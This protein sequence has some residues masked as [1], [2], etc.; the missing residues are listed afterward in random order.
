MR[1]LL[2]FIINKGSWGL[3]ILLEIF[4]FV[5][6][7]RDNPYQ[8]TAIL[9]SANVV[10][11]NISSISG[12]INSYFNLRVINKDLAEKNSHMEMELLKL[13][14]QIDVMKADT[15]AFKGFAESSEDSFSYDFVMARVIN[16]SVGYLSN[17]I[18]IDKGIKDGVT[19]DM[20]VVSE[21]GVVGVVVT[22]SENMAVVLPIINSKSILSCQV[23]GSGYGFLD[24][25]GTN[26]Q[27]AK[28]KISRHMNIQ[29]GDTIITS[30]YSSIFPVGLVVGTISSSERHTDD[31]FYF[32]NVRLSTNFQTLSNVRVIRNY[33]RAEQISLEQSA[34]DI[35]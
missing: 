28:M 10:V 1:K 35:S 17:Y 16:N 5:L 27:Y 34:N 8:R 14:D 21:R 2:D 26:L 19:K 9:S 7:Y 13:Q 24:W 3:F 23:K 29:E 25:D 32:L 18:T 4:A 11:G 6:I 33:R 31:N 12:N 30:G 22:A 15:I 20:G